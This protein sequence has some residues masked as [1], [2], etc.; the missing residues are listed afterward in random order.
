M[1]NLLSPPPDAA[2]MASLN[3]DKARL[4]YARIVMR[5]RTLG[6][7]AAILTALAGLVIAVSCL[8]VWLAPDH[9]KAATTSASTHSAAAAGFWSH[10][11]TEGRL[12]GVQQPGPSTTV[13]F[14]PA[15]QGGAKPHW[16][17]SAL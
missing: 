17:V 12:P 14:Q 3:S 15:T 11:S 6:G 16:I 8:V 4:E 5:P 9:P 10:T 1:L 2:C 13:V 7:W